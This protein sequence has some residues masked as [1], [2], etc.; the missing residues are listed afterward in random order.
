MMKYLFVGRRLTKEQKELRRLREVVTVLT[1]EINE[2][3]VHSLTPF[4]EFFEQ[5]K[6]VPGRPDFA[7]QLISASDF[8]PA[9]TVLNSLKV[10]MRLKVSEGTFKEE[11][12]HLSDELDVNLSMV[13]AEDKRDYYSFVMH[14]S[15]EGKLSAVLKSA[16]DLVCNYYL[17]GI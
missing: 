6:A 12:R 8:L 10:R 1:A 15:F 14:K 7:E 3:F 9:L 4:I 13:K 2:S 16:F 17:Q 5:N 11:L